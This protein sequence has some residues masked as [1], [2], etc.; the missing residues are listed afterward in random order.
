MTNLNKL[1]SFYN[2]CSHKEKE[3]L[4]DLLINHLPKEYTS[5]VI[6]KLKTEGV[7]VKSG[8]VRNVKNGLSKNIIVFNAIVSVASE[9]KL[10]SD[11]MK[12]TLDIKESL[13]ETA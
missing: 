2:V 12:K 6:E 4:E 13:K 5:K 11:R 1:Y 7:A 10:F 8:L 9:Y 3:S